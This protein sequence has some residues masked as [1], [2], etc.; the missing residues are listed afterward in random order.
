MALW[1]AGTVTGNLRKPEVTSDLLDSFELANGVNHNLRLHGYGGAGKVK[2]L[3]LAVDP[4]DG[5]TELAEEVYQHFLAHHL[6]FN[7]G[8]RES[9]H[10]ITNPANHYAF[11]DPREKVIFRAMAEWHKNKVQKL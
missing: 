8:D 6:V 2:P 5:L 7:Y 3:M 1:P 10:E 11:L 4:M 9:A